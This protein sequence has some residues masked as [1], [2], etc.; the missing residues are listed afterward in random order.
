M[1][2][3][4]RSAQILTEATGKDP[5]LSRQDYRNKRAEFSGQTQL[6]IDVH[7]QFLRQ[8]EESDAGRITEKNILKSLQL[9]NTSIL[10]LYELHLGELTAGEMAAM[11]LVHP[12]G[13]QIAA[14][15]KRT[16]MEQ[17]SQSSSQAIFERIRTLTSDLFFD[18]LG[19]EADQPVEAIWVDAKVIGDL[20]EAALAE[21]LGLDPTLPQDKIERFQD[22]NEFFPTFVD[23]HRYFGKEA[24]A[25]EL[26]EI[27]QTYLRSQK[28]AVI[29]EDYNP[30]VDPEHPV[31]LLG[32]AQD[33]KLVG[34][35]SAVIWT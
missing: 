4:Q 34:I 8:L 2:T 6:L 1:S 18:F 11:A 25:L 20:T 9:F 16:A 5:Y 35:K 28:L 31:Y 3:I 32:V 22:A 13:P 12:F 14:Q 21:A 27:M 26:V 7:H 24:A 23:L 30:Q 19:S 17:K 29:G 10:P 15:V 33:G